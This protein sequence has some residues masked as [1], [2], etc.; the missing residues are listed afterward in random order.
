[1]QDKP[2]SSTHLTP[3]QPIQI[4]DPG[5]PPRNVENQNVAMD[6]VNRLSEPGDGLEDNGRVVLTYAMLRALRPAP[7]QRPPS[8]EIVLHL[9]G[10]MTRYI[11]GFDAKKFSE[12][13][14]IMLGLGERVR[15][16]LINDTMMEHPIHLHGFWSELENG[17]GALRPNKH[18]ILSQPGSKLSYL[19]T[20]DTPGM[21]ALHCHLI[22]HMHLGMFRTVVVS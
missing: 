6:P 10:N 12:A 13:P 22:Y 7:D 8:R 5:P 15:I 1:P 2:A 20:A 4:D 19:V 16:T 21:W 11:W 17:Q 9:T 18:T 14:P 3:A